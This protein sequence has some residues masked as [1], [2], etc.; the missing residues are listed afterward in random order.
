MP[1]IEMLTGLSGMNAPI[2]V[3]SSWNRTMSATMMIDTAAPIVAS[4]PT[5]A[6]CAW[7]GLI[8]R[9]YG[10]TNHVAITTSTIRVTYSP[11][12]SSASTR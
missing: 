11:S 6:R 10:A 2:T 3:A 9:A 7:N 1:K 4:L 12:V 5:I 8:R